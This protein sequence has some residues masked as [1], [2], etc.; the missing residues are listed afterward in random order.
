MTVARKSTA[1]TERLTI[2]IQR[3]TTG[4]RRGIP[5]GVEFRAWVSMAVGCRG[6]GEVVIRIVDEAESAR[7]NAAYRHKHGP[8]NVLSFPADRDAARRAAQL[9]DIVICAALVRR[10]ARAQGKTIKSH[11]AHLTMHGALHLVGYDHVRSGDARKMEAREIR[12][13]RRL[14]F[15][16]PYVARDGRGRQ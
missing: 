14:G 1:A 10:E 16:N 3:A 9:G 8:T 15:A 5:A 6:R 13:M 7:L 4:S 12:L 2:A 11:W